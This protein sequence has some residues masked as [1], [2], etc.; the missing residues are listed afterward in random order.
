[1]HRERSHIARTLYEPRAGT[2][3]TTAGTLAA[4]GWLN[5]LALTPPVRPP[6]FAEV[7]LGTEQVVPSLAFDREVA[8]RLRLEIYSVEW[9]V[10]FCHGGRSSWIRVTDVPFTHG[11]DDFNLRSVTPPLKDV[12]ALV[13]ALEVAYELRFARELAVVRSN[14]R[15]AEQALRPWLRSL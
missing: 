12:G 3:T 10:F 15:G 14:L 1:M 6:W 11:R 9:G 13:R 4:R 5:G 7:T 2:S 8:T